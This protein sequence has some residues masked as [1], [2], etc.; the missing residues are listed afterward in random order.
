MDP[1]HVHNFILHNLGQEA[2]S[3]F[4]RVVRAASRRNPNPV[5]SRPQIPM[6][7]PPPP[8]QPNPPSP[9]P[10][11]TP[12]NYSRPSKP[13]MTSSRPNS[14]SHYPQ[15]SPPQ[16]QSPPQNPWQ[17]VPNHSPPPL[18][19]PPGY[20]CGKCNNTG[21]KYYNGSPCGDC[22]RLFGVQTANVLF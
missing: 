17:R 4:E 5:P 13:I 3:V 7:Y 1:N 19:Y 9:R 18:R 22:S 2:A 10:S 14:P 21:I 15:P 16:W 20:L 12:L 6:Q 11:Y 8:Y